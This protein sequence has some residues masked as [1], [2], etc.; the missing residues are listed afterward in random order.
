MPYYLNW[1]SKL[2]NEKNENKLIVRSIDP[3]LVRDMTREEALSIK[4][5]ANMDKAYQNAEHWLKYREV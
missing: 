5:I 4:K 2:T 3:S 1:Q